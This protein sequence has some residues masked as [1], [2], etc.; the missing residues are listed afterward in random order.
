MKDMTVACQR[1]N[2]C[3][4]VCYVSCLPEFVSMWT[5]MKYGLAVIWKNSEPE[6]HQVAEVKHGLGVRVGPTAMRSGRFY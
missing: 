2:T 6:V 4:I 3:M 5:E 1:N